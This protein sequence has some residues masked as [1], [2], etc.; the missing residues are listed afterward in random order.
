MT[1]DYNQDSR[2]EKITLR[3]SANIDPASVRSIAILQ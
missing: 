2:P 1:D 3:V